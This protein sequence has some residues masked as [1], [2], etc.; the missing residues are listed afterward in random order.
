VYH[1]D[2]S[3]NGG[4]DGCLLDFI[5][6]PP[7]EGI[8]PLLSVTPPAFE[9]TLAQG[10]STSDS[11]LLSNLGG[12]LLKYTVMV[13]DTASNKKDLQADNL[14]GS[15]LTCN[16]ENFV[17]GQAINWVF[18][19]KNQSAD[20]EYIRH[21]KLDFPP[22]VVIS[23]ATNF[24]GG[25]LGDLTFLGIPGNGTSLDWHGESSGGRGVIKP[26]ETAVATVTGTIGE[27]FM[28]DVFVV[29]ALRGDS[30]GT[31]PHEQPGS[32]KIKNS[33]IPNNWVSLTNPTGSLLGNETG[34][35][36]VN[37]NTAGLVP[38]TYQCDLIARDF[39]NNKVVVPV[40][41]HV[42]WPVSIRNSSIPTGKGLLSNFPNPFCGETQIRFGLAAGS[43]VT[44]DIYSLQGVLLRSWQFSALDAGDHFLVWDGKDGHGRLLPS[45]IYS[46]RMKTND[47][48][49]S[50][51]MILFR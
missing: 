15:Y 41:L 36:G 34:A 28:N 17:P 46:C 6:L 21:I 27:T 11:L 29:S 24:S 50:L 39:Y 31:S 23:N 9:K 13:F 47:Y 19:V 40:T 30:L 45:G 48:Q 49:G 12:G 3:L 35:V 22:G 38:K 37:F 26:G 7:I 16:T 32:V 33:G 43:D 25:S 20:N 8:I 42:T 1:K 2:N 5:T 44:L 4:W 10:Q 51:K 14:T 18:T